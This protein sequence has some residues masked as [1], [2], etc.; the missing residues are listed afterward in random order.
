MFRSGIDR[1]FRENQGQYL[2]SEALAK[3]KERA[4]ALS[5]QTQLGRWEDPFFLGAYTND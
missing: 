3:A 2:D 5:V 1:D 4:I